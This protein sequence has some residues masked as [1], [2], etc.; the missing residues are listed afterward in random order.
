MWSKNHLFFSFHYSVIHVEC[1]DTVWIIGQEE[2]HN[3][4]ALPDHSEEMQCWISA[5]LLWHMLS[6]EET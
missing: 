2:Q 6:D 5:S 3:V 1:T 4:T